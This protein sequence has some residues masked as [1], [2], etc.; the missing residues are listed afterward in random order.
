MNLVRNLVGAVAC[1]ALLPLAGLGQQHISNVTAGRAAEGKP[2]AIAVELTQNTDVQRLLLRYRGF[3]TTEFKELEMLISGRNASVTIPGEAVVPPTVEYY[4]EARLTSGKNETYPLGAPDA[5]PL[6]LE[7]TP[8]NPRDKEVRILSPEPGET[9]AVE[10]LVVAISF[11]YASPGVN[12]KATRIFLDGVDVS[13]KAVF[14]DDVVLYSPKNFTGPLNLGAHFLKVELRDTTGEPYH[15]IEST[16]ALS[17][18]AAI[19]AE[20]ARLQLLGNAQLEVRDEALAAGSTTY[21]RGDTRLDG[22]YGSLNF[23]GNVHLDNQNTADRQPQNRFLLYG[24]TDFLRIQVGDAFPKF[25]SDIMSG[26]RVRGITGNLALGFFNLDVTYGQTERYVEGK[27]EDRDSLVSDPSARAALTA[28]KKQVNDSTF[29]FFQPGVYTRNL[30]AV[31]PS[32]GGGENFQLGFTYLHAKDDT[33]SISYGIR[34]KENL[35]VGS[36]MLI[37]FDDQRFKLEG[38]ASMGMSNEDITGGSFTQA[39]YDSMKAASE[40]DLSGLG[41]ILDK[42]ITVNQNLFPTNPGS[43]GL[44]GVAAQAVLTLNYLNNYVRGTLFHRGAAYKSFANEFLQTD[45]AGFQISD[46]IRLFSNRVYAAVSYEHKSDN[47]AS[48]KEVTTAY[49]NLNTSVSVNPGSDLPTFQLGYGRYTRLAPVDFSTKLALENRP[50]SSSVLN[51]AD[52]GTNRIFGGASYDFD[53]GVRHTAAFNVTVSS[54]SDNTF[55]KLNQ[56]NLYLQA[57]VVSQVMAG[58]QT[59]VGVVYSKNR[60][61]RE[62]FSGAGAFL[63]QDSLL[64]TTDFNY[65]AV[66]LGAQARMLDNALR[67]IGSINPTL[68]AISRQEY[69]LGAEYTVAQQHVFLLQVNYLQNSGTKD[70]AILSFIYRLNF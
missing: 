20:K 16:F 43:K 36:D 57:S 15:T 44:P 26:K 22:T 52:E 37:A 4:I 58:W 42:F 48:T 27:P 31:R 65:T 60:N 10:D 29:R 63:N 18:A 53:A 46:N 70:D 12:T 61:E 66:T 24:G 30:I 49:N 25:P 38:Q 39:Q 34:P 1:L 67:L 47:T 69:M 6:R 8:V 64:V 11:F 23:G 21:I 2:V 41:K 59:T 14:S 17:T 45:M 3:G 33:A 13:A 56:S 62:A 32:F 35:V 7:V 68:G 9:V 55:R 40:N 51:S 5:T 50:D 54:R 19:A 28:N